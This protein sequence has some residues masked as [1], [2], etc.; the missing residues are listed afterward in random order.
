MKRYSRK[1]RPH[2]LDH[3]ADCWCEPRVI[4][5]DDGRIFVHTCNVCEHNPCICP[6][7]IIE[8]ED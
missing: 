1:M 6:E 7:N 8:G 5:T 4:Q 2:D 3:E